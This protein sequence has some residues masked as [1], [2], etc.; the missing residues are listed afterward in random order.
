M[1]PV[2]YNNMTKAQLPL[3][4]LQPYQYIKGVCSHRSSYDT[5]P[6]YHDESIATAVATAQ[7]IYYLSSV[8]IAVAMEPELYNNVLKAV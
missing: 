7:T 5:S 8:A 3:Q 1:A 4:Q 6:I 2:L